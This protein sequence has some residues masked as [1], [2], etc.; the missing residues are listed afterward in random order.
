MVAAL[1]AFAPALHGSFVFDDFNLPFAA[2][3][4]GVMPARFWIGGA[5]PVL[6]LTYWANY[7]I[8]GTDTLSYH[9]AN[10]MLHAATAVLAF[11]I[12]ERLFDLAGTNGR[13]RAYGV[14][15]A[16][17]FLLHP[18]QTESVDY[19]AGR[20][21]L[22]SGF[23][24]CASWLL[25]LR[26][27]HE[28][29]RWKTSAGILALG[30]AAV[31]AKENAICLPAV[32][33]ATDLY[34]ADGSLRA[35]LSTTIRRKMKLYVPIALGGVAGAA[36]ILTRLGAGTGAG[37]SSGVTRFEYALTQCRVIL[38]YLRLFFV[39]AGQSG[40][41]QLQFFHSFNDG[42]AWLWA[43][44]ALGLV[45]A[46][47]WLARRNRMASFGLLLFLLMLAPTSSVVPIKDALTERRMYIPIIG[48][49]LACGGAT[50]TLTGRLR[51]SQTGLPK[52][53][54]LG[55]F[56]ILLALLSVASWRRSAVWTGPVEFWGDVT[57]KNPAN[58]RAHVGLGNALF[59][60]RDCRSAALEFAVARQLDT[61][62]EA[63]TWDLGKALQCDGQFEAALP[64]LQSSAL[65]NPSAETWNQ[66]AYVAARLGRLDDVSSAVDKA[67][68][69]DPGNATSYAY[70]G[71]CRLAKDDLTGARQDVALALSLDPHNAAALEGERQ[72]AA[73]HQK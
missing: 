46:V 50:E 49:I 3:N 10:I 53:A 60:L 47:A 7:L 51:R 54:Q 15:G 16:A 37:T 20:S 33:F 9:L 66:V 8:S 42:A 57:R 2:P 52:A 26:F 22:V 41:W 56:A 5:R 63:I 67:L 31:L 38:L 36:W 64:L 23:L 24:F 59:E 28:E 13:S 40:D 32:L 27:F 55:I 69:I 68:T 70:R 44:G 14:A 35:A 6:M 61:A 71:L 17:I 48:L 12:L 18:L 43:V 30:G 39:P 29:T 34:W 65:T 73:A 11:Y 4:A 21:E 19:I 62:K 45:A 1:I 72:I 25:F 58:M